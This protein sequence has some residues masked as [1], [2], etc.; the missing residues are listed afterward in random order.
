[1]PGVIS[2]IKAMKDVYNY[3]RYGIGKRC[4]YNVQSMMRLTHS[5]R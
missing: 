1:M 2:L 4:L 3:I 5:S